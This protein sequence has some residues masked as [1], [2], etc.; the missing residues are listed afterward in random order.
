LRVGG[1]IGLVGFIGI[2]VEKLK[3]EEKEVIPAG[4]GNR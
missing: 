1:S 4:W 3:Q 2:V